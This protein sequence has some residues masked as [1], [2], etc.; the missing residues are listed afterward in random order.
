MNIENHIR[1]RFKKE[2][3]K[4]TTTGNMEQY[5]FCLSFCIFAHFSKFSM[6]AWGKKRKNVSFYRGVCM[7]K[8]KT[9]TLNFTLLQ[10][11]TKQPIRIVTTFI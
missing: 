5:I 9:N 7:C 6:Y 11:L 4:L 3:G 2:G 1:E 8:G 10:R